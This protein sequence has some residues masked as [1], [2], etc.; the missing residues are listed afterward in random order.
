MVSQILYNNKCK[1]GK[2]IREQSVKETLYV[3]AKIM[4]GAMLEASG[5]IAV[6]FYLFT[7]NVFLI[8]ILFAILLQMFFQMPSE[9]SFK[10]DFRE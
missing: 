10:R 9:E 3:Q 7:K 2:K 1:E 4:Q 8:I 5:I 6:I